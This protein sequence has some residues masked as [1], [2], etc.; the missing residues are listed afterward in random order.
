[1]LHDRL[2]VIDDHE[3]VFQRQQ[4]IK[5]PTMPLPS[6]NGQRVAIIGGSPGTGYAVAECALGEGAQVVIGS[7]NAANVEAALVRLG[8]GA[9][10][11]GVAVRDEASVATFFELLRAFAHLVFTA[12]DWGPHL[13]ASPI[14]QM[15]F[16]SASEAMMKI[17]FWGAL[18]AIKHAQGRISANGSFTLTDGVLAHKPRKGAP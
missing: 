3:N 14:A 9:S 7:S 6:L 11:G 17:R 10:G 12:W 4:S 1:L 2:K 16:G 13:L 15:D 5:E 18:M 8:Q